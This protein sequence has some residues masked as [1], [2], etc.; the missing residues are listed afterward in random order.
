VNFIVFSS[1]KFREQFVYRRPENNGHFFILFMDTMDT[2]D[3]LT[4]SGL[5]RPC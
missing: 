1:S 3:A 2:M 5:I 4:R